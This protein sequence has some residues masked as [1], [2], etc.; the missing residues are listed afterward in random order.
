M[1]TLK[2]A[3][4]PNCY[5]CHCANKAKTKKGKNLHEDRITSYKLANT[6]IDENGV[7]IYCEHYAIFKRAKLKERKKIKVIYSVDYEHA[8]PKAID[9]VE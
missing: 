7:C 8:L 9:K 5:Y 3:D 2:Y 1:K 4:D 6:E